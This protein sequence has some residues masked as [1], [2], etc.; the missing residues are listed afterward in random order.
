MPRVD[1]G[2]RQKTVDPFGPV[3]GVGNAAVEGIEGGDFC[4]PKGFS[5][6]LNGDGTD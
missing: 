3:H 5:I 2:D 1:L 4:F 6:T